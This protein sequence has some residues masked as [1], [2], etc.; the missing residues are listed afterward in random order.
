MPEKRGLKTQYY[1]ASI[2]PTYL[3][4]FDKK[5]AE[6]KKAGMAEGDELEREAQK[7]A[8]KQTT[9]HF[10]LLLEPKDKAKAW[11]HIY[12]AHVARKAG[13]NVTP[14][15]IE[16][17]ISADQSWK[18]SSGHAFEEV[19]KELGNG[20]L[21]GTG[22]ELV[23]QRDIHPLID[24]GAIKND[25][26]DLDWL[27]TQISSSVFDLFVM[28]EGFIFGCVQAKTSIRDRVTRDREPSMNAMKHFFWSIVFVLDGDF[29]KLP[30]FQHMVNGGN[31]EF[32]DNGWHGLYAFSLPDE[33]LNTRI[34]LLDAKLSVF[35]LHAELAA[36]QWFGNRQWFNKDWLPGK[37]NS[38]NKESR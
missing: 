25:A 24:G 37:T 27:K 36:A 34:N 19:V 12:A 26:R 35:K 29:L 15:T 1:F 33:K 18:K 8:I 9:L 5:R 4:Y 20:A 17:V 10:F 22:I 11:A 6:L 14:E 31:D 30:K 3:G 23:L 32:L 13:I 21:V 38:E 7:Y 2:G 28:K 16:K